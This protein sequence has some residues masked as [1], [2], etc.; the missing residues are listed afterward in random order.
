M[1]ILVKENINYVLMLWSL[2][3]RRRRKKRREEVVRKPA[4]ITK[5]NDGCERC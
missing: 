1:L 5:K 3:R 4:F 2:K